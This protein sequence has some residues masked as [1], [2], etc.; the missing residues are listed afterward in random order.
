MSDQGTLYMVATPI[1]NLEDITLRALR[2]LKEVDLIA[3]EDTRHTQKL[4]SHFS[5]SK[6]LISYYAQN[7]EGRTPQLISKLKDG[8]NIALVS[9][10]GTPGISDPGTLLVSQAIAEEIDVIPI[11]GPCAAIAALS[12]SGLPTDRFYFHGFLPLKPG[13]R[14][15]LLKK[16][17]ELETTLVFYESGRRLFRFFVEIQNI[18]PE[19]K[20]VLAREMTK[21]YEEFK[22]GLPSQIAQ[23]IPREGLKGECVILIDNR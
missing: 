22:R 20:T 7:Q 18:F 13:K 8:T 19:K 16:L 6:P 5:I 12:A 11:A 1:G 21:V 14:R 3:C 2:V 4:L 9:D 15:T 17:S 10:A 23:A